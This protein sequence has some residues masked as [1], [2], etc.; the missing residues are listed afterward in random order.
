MQKYADI[1]ENVKNKKAIAI[2]SWEVFGQEGIQLFYLSSEFKLIQKM[3]DLFLHNEICGECEI[4]D[5]L[6]S[7]CK[8]CLLELFFAHEAIYHS[9]KVALHTC[10]G[11]TMLSNQKKVNFL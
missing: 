4:D 1:L 6:C 2:N 5:D 10:G 7:I 8:S 9:S 11:C 3:E